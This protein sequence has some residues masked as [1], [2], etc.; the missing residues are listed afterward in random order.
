[1][2]PMPM[3][4]RRASTPQSRRCFAWRRVTTLPPMTWRS[5]NSCFI[6]RMMSCWKTLSPW[7]LSTTTASTPAETSA[8]TRSRSVGRVP[9]AAATMRQP[10]PSL[11]ASG[12]SACFRRSV[13]ATSATR[14][15]VLV[16]MGSLPFLEDWMASLA[17]ASSTPSSAVTRSFNAVMTELTRTEVRSITKSVSRFVTRPRSLEPIFPF[18][19]TGKP[20]K[21]HCLRSSSSS[22]SS[23]VGWMQ[24]GSMMK[25]LRYRFTFMTSSDCSWIDMLVWMTPMPPCKAIP[26]AILDS[27]TVSMGLETMGVFSLMVLENWESKT[28]SPTPKLTC[29]GRQIRSS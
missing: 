22:E 15:P 18:S 28:T 20:V 24:T 27:V 19:V 17:C 16:T 25:P 21:P 26:I 29:P 14:R 7:L 8:R 2:E 5:G 3:P 1:M 4:T 13:R 6:H 12:K 11:V 10:L 23:M 9:T